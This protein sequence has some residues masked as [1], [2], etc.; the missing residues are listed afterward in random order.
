MLKYGDKWKPRAYD[1]RVHI[2]L[3]VEVICIICLQD[4]LQTCSYF[5]LTDLFDHCSLG[6]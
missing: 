3:P 6:S 4:F 5:Y 1:L 2:E